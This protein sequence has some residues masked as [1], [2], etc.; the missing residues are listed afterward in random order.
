MTDIVIEEVEFYFVWTKTGHIP[1]KVHQ[2][3]ADAEAE[4]DRLAGL[5]PHGK[6]YIILRAIRKCH[7]PPATDLIPSLTAPACVPAGAL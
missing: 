6:K 3:L 4:A 1:R 2:T 5:R 7:F